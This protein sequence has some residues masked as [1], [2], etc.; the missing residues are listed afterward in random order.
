MFVSFRLMEKAM[1]RRKTGILEDLLEIT[2]A[3][4]WWMGA[5]FAVIAYGVLHQD[6]SLLLDSINGTAQFELDPNRY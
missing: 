3:L 1:V 2:A 6:A 4:P 5:T